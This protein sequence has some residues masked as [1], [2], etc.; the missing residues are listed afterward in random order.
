MNRLFVKTNLVI[1]TLILITLLALSTASF[2][3]SRNLIPRFPEVVIEKGFSEN[4]LITDCN[5]KVRIQNNE[6]D[7]TIK[8]NLKNRSNKEL[9]SS[10]KFRILYPT[11][12]SQI[13]I[14]INGQ[15][16]NYSRQFSRHA[17]T[18]KPQEGL[19]I[20]IST[21]TSVNYS[22][23]SVREALRKD[24]EEQAKKGK[25]FDLG[26]L[27]KLFDREKFGKRFMVGPIASKWGVFPLDFDKVEL[28]IIVP[29]D[30]AIVAQNPE[31]WTSRQRNRETIHNFTGNEGFAGAVFL[32]EN[33]KDEFI[34]AQEILTSSEFMH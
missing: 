5:A 10:I 3:A 22:I 16:F 17:F 6:A 1:N 34:K 4:F 14:K 30:F 26:N 24:N 28:E 20:E 19:A 29:A 8:L 2:A 13:R 7:S 32:P 23:D 9:K 18:L 25:K 12:E 31:K 27:M 11:S 15:A 21:R 33:E